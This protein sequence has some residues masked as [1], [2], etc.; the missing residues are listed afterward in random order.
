MV[1]S[2]GASPTGRLYLGT[3]DGH[4]F[5]STDGAQ[6]W[7][8]RGRVGNRLGAVV[9]RVIAD[10][11]DER[12]LS[13]AVWYQAAHA[14]GGVF[15]SE[16]AGQTWSLAGLSGEE[17]R[18]LEAAPSKP[19]Q[20]V[21]GT[22]T[23]VFRSLDR[24][25]NWS[26]ISPSGDVE[27]RN[28]DS[29][30]IDPRDSETI[31]VGTYHLPWRTSDGGKS[32]KPITAGIIDDSD[33]MSLRVDAAAPDR[34]YMS[35]CS[36]IYRS[37]N[38]GDQWI[39]L[40]GIPYA[41]RRTQ[42][43][44]Q[45]GAFPRIIYAG[46]TKGLW[47]TRDAGESWAR[48]TPKDWVVNSMVVL[49]GR[50]GRPGRVVLGTEGQGVQIS[51]DAGATFSGANRGFSHVVVRQLLGDRSEAGHLLMLMEQGGSQIR[52]SSDDGKSW[53]PLSLSASERGK[54][55]ELRADQIRE[56]YPAP[57][58]W[59]LQ[60]QDGSFWVREHG[61]QAWSQ[62]NLKLPLPARRPAANKAARPA[63]EG[64]IQPHSAIPP[65][66]FT[67]DSAVLPS[68]E[69]LLLCISSGLCRWL[70]GFGRGGEVRAIWVSADGE[71]MGIVK[72]GKLGLS[73]DGGETTSWQDLPVANEKVLWLDVHES[74]ATKA[75]YLGTTEGL[76][77]SQDGGVHWRKVASGLPA[78][79]LQ[80]WLRASSFWLAAESDD[81]MYLSIDQGN[82]WSRM[83][84]DSERGHFAG[85]VATK[86]GTILAGSQNE[87]LLRIELVP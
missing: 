71:E 83:D 79:R 14:G 85:L 70:E 31:Y 73:S 18:A 43:I 81:G 29:V 64:K 53:A 38:Q 16:D 11:R 41:A 51:D 45:D 3:T 2:L 57:W 68:A 5:V 78:G 19:E 22:R 87:G 62:W 35:A 21:A 27:L 77:V 33:I 66:A 50:G 23:G 13:A 7:E 52:E 17:V 59:L 49:P 32:W 8:I 55:T 26:R 65:I 40:Q 39:K 9:T 46:T 30:A 76:V 42:A 72:D 84:R 25:K 74:S 82:S 28:V 4:V 80:L 34:L 54:H 10:P 67:K 48:T 86:D 56:A 47:V 61:K 69:G 12:R 58:G 60:M 75:M 1:V 24:G 37:D 44:A 36:G 63:K 15:R 20:L 6:T